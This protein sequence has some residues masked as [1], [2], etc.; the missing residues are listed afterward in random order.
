MF[1]RRIHPRLGFPPPPVR[2][3]PSAAGRT[4]R[5]SAPVRLSTPETRLGR[6]P[7][8]A[9]AKMAE[10]PRT[11]RSQEAAGIA[12]GGGGKMAAVRR[13]MSNVCSGHRLQTSVEV[14]V[15]WKL[16]SVP[17][18]ML[19]WLSGAFRPLYFLGTLLLLVYKCQ[20]FS[21]PQDHLVLDVGLL[22]T[23]GV[24]ETAGL[25]YGAKGNLM[26]AEGPLAVSLLLTAGTALLAAYFLCWQTLVL[27]ADMALSATRLTLHVLEAMLQMVTIAAFVS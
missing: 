16:S 7:L 25:Y 21:Y 6:A 9:G 15:A 12:A 23:M 13:V 19:W 17:L 20:V 1:P 4:S 10:G 26:E 5:A 3:Y 2:K 22:M 8:G 18:Q 14:Q 24:L 11:E 27:W